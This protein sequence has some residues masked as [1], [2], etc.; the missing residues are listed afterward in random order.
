MWRL[1]ELVFGATIG[2]SVHAFLAEFGMIAGALACAAVGIALVSI[3][4]AALSRWP[5]VGGIYRSCRNALAYVAF[6]AAVL[7]AGE[8]DGYRRRGALDASADLRGQ[9]AAARVIRDESQRRE[10]I[11]KGA[12]ET[13]VGRANTLAGEKAALE[14]RNKDLDDASH[15]RDAEPCLDSGGLQR[16]DQIR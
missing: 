2:A 10:A 11:Y 3:D 6:G 1:F 5:I 8:F 7:L 9:L 4:P 16:L 12:Y 15:A 14:T 13:A